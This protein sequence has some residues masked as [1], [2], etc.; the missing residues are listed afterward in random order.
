MS[1]LKVK[2]CGLRDRGNIE[3][4]LLWQP[5]YVGFIFYEKSPRY[6][7]DVL[8]PAFVRNLPPSVQKVGVFVNADAN[9]IRQHHADFG[10]DLVQLHGDESPDDCAAL[11][12]EGLRL[13]K[14]FGVDDDFDFGQTDAY[15]PHCAF[16]LFDTAGAARG[17]NGVAF[18]W[19]RLERYAGQTPF[20]LSGGIGLDSLDH[21]PT[22]PQ[23]YALDVNSRFER[24]PGYKNVG[25]IN[26]LLQKVRA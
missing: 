24:S 2:V 20:F 8:S 14:V 17:G 21:L 7:G 25:E 1:R 3:S 5:D 23:L 4:L 6:V 15:A 13:I 19:Q 11:R 22:H 12:A 9:A 16:F 10:L 18:N 26:A